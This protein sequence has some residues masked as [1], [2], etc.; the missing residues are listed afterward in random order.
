MQAANIGVLVFLGICALIAI[1][2]KIYL[3]GWDKGYKDG[4]DNGKRVGHTK[5]MYEYSNKNENDLISRQEVIS[6]AELII[7]E[8]GS[9]IKCVRLKNIMHL[10]SIK[11]DEKNTDVDSD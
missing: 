11:L 9:M 7:D 5:E 10:P 1:G 2:T 3:Y 8:D 6:K 4:Y